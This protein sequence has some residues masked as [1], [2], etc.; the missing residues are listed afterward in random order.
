[1]RQFLK[2][3]EKMTKRTEKIKLV[4]HFQFLMVPDNFINHSDSFRFISVSLSAFKKEVVFQQLDGLFFSF[5]LC[6]LK[7]VF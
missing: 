2:L 5:D 7:F 6:E 4:A 3:Q 1:M